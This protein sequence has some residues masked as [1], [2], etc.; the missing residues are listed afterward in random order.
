MSSTCKVGGKRYFCSR[1]SNYLVS[2]QTDLKRS[3]FIK[4]VAT[5]GGAGPVS[6]T[7]L[8]V[9]KRQLLVDF[10]N[11]IILHYERNILQ[12]FDIL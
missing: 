4:S 12:P 11:Q 3:T 6:Y 5:V 2:D 7:H 10:I 9:Y 1:Y 8:D